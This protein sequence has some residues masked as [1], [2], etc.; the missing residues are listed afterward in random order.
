MAGYNTSSAY[1]FTEL[2]TA[3]KKEAAPKLK[4]VK[5]R[6]RI[7]SVSSILF[8]PS[9]LC[10]FAIVVALIVL[11]VYNQV[12]LNILTT[13][14]NSL[15]SEM[16]VLQSENV[17]LSSKL[18]SMIST[19][20][21]RELATAMGMQARDEYQTERIYLYNEDKIERTAATPQTTPGQTAKLAVT[22]LFSLFKE[23]LNDR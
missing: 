3:V 4:V 15:S 9:V 10:A 14:I 17:K 22:S 18:E 21:L 2:E 11:M 6:S 13:E 7:S 16:E 23:Y 5:N 8:S 20:E 19:P 1:K 12:Q